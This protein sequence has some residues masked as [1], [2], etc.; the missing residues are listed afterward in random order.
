[1]LILNKYYCY[2]ILL[3]YKCSAKFLFYP[4]TFNGIFLALGHLEFKKNF[5]EIEIHVRFTV[6]ICLRVSNDSGKV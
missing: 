2:V 4:V 1:M 3:V 6:S 5:L